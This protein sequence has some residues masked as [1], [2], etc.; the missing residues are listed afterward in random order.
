MDHNKS[1]S[2]RTQLLKEKEELNK[3]IASLNQGLSDSMPDSIS[4]LSMYDNHP[5]DIGDELFERSKDLSLRDSAH[6]Q[7]QNVVRALER[8]DDQTYGIC[9]QCGAAIDMARLEVMPSAELCLPCKKEQTGPDRTPRP[10]EEQVIQ[11]PFGNQRHGDGS[12]ESNAF[13]GEDAWQAVARFGTADTPQDLEKGNNAQ[14]PN[15][16]EEWEE[17][18]SGVEDVDQIPYVRT[19]DGI[20]HQDFS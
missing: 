5:A 6:I 12:S 18:L 14:Y 2:F 19:K 3:S 13:D 8:I 20:I 4:E 15:I 16:Y 7:Y 1:A 9:A 11:P 10:I 17:D